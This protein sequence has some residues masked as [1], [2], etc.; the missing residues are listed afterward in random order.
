MEVKSIWELKYKPKNIKE[1]IGRDDLI[2]NLIKL[3]DNGNIPHLMF[4]GPKGY[5]K[6]NCAILF[7]KELLGDSFISNCKVV[8]ASDP[9]TVEERAIVKQESYVSTKKIGS[10]AGKQFT[11]PAFL[12]SRIKPFVEIKPIGEFPYKILIVNDFHTLESE[13]D[14]FRRLMEKY[15]EICRMILITNQISSIIDP[16]L[17]RCMLFFFNQID[18]NSYKNFISNV[19]K[20]ENLKI[21]DND[22]YFLYISTNGKIGETL[23]LLQQIST[24]TSNITTDSIHEYVRGSIKLEI[25]VLTK[26]ILLGD[27]NLISTKL[28]IIQSYGYDI[29]TILSEICNEIFNLPLNKYQKATLINLL[30]DLDY[31]ALNGSDEELQLNNIIYQ[32]ISLMKK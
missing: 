4:I 11:W 13:Q 28:K 6:L 32:I 8:H 21:S 17:S 9:L 1:I 10:M 16:I 26:A 24:K 19:I 23:N 27:L 25:K 18:F 14:G 7:A 20:N 2:N 22:L 29:S 5:G 15:S 12:A 30:G 31:Q 3:K